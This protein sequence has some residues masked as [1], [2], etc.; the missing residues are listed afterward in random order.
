V[1]LSDCPVRLELDIE[2]KLAL[3]LAQF[4]EV[5]VAAVRNYRPNYLA[6]YLYELSQ[7]YSNFYQNVPFM[8]AE[9]GVR[10][11]RLRL[12]SAVARV[13]A[14]GLELLGIE[15]PERI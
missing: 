5:I 11:S 6:D 9:P 7:I 4:G 8:K 2:R 15:A 14:K 12:C 10:E 3:R 1:N 13:L